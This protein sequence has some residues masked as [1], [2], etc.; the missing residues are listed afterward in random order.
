MTTTQY[1]KCV[2]FDGILSKKHGWERIPPYEGGV[3]SIYWL[4]GYDGIEITNFS[5]W[6]LKNNLL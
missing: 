1:N 6:H 2:Y 5:N 4:A 3:A